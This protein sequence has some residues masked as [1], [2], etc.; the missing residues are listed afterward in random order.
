ML[1]KRTDNNSPKVE[2]LISILDKTIEEKK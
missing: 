1:D 2:T